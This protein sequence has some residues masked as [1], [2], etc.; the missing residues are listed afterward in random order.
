MC[1]VY[2]Y[3]SVL[4][5]IAD[6]RGFEG[7]HRDLGVEQRIK[8]A[9]VVPVPAAQATAAG[10]RRLVPLAKAS[11]A[12]IFSIGEA[13]AVFFAARSGLDTMSYPTTMSL[14]FILVVTC[15]C[16]G[17]ASRTFLN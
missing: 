13:R 5:V 16:S 2:E 17:S 9:H 14:W 1:K 12:V 4:N 11:T 7:S 6:N 10:R 8:I 15:F 3:V